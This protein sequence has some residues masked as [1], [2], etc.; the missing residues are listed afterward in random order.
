MLSGL[1]LTPSVVPLD[2]IT[3]PCKTIKSENG[4]D[5]IVGNVDDAVW[6]AFT[7]QLEQIDNVNVVIKG[8]TIKT[9]KLDS[10]NIFLTGKWKEKL[11]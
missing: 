10:H 7:K 4:Y 3:L 1:K 9:L 2:V 5:L 6:Q 8:S 11:Q